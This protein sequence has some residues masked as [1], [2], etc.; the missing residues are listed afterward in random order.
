LKSTAQVTPANSKKSWLSLSPYL[1]LV[2][3]VSCWAGNFVLGR[4]IHSDIPPITLTFWR[5][6]VAG[7]VLLPFAAPALWA[8]RHILARHWKLMVVLAATGV[9][10]FH[11]SVYIALQT[12]TATNAA[13]VFATVPVLI[14]VM[15][16]VLFREPVT[17][18]QVLGTAISLAGVT[19]IIVRGDP[20]ILANLELTRGDLWILLAV[21]VWSM[22]SVLLR[23][24]PRGVPTLAIILAITGVGLV[25]LAPLYVWEFNTVGGFELTLANI[26]SIGYVALFASVL[27]Y[28]CWNRAVGEVGAN[29]AGLFSHLMPVFST[30]LAFVFLDE[31][32]QGFHFAGI[33]AIASG[34]YLT[35]TA[36]RAKRI[37]PTD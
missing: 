21:L 27:A 14:P 26:L 5:W 10:L 15:S 20:A 6:A 36:Y 34:L 29:K 30:L 24:V 22:Y 8:H 11:I 23:R 2:M 19:V 13:L 12:T 1:L 28:I 37:K 35:T 32:L 7:V 25:F 16:L 33:A 31:G 3:A 4:A 18:R 17:V 9:G